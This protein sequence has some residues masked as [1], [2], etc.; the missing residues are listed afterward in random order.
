MKRSEL[1]KSYSDSVSVE[2]QRMRYILGT[3]IDTG[4]CSI[5]LVKSV[6]IPANATWRSGSQV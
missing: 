1:V 3:T 4:S 5:R 2:I 6:E